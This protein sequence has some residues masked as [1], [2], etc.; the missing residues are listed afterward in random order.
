MKRLVSNTSPKF[1]KGSSSNPLGHAMRSFLNYRH[2][3]FEVP[4][5]LGSPCSLWWDAWIPSSTLLNCLSSQLNAR[6]LTPSS[7]H[8]LH[9]RG[10]SS[11][12]VMALQRD[13]MICLHPNLNSL[14]FQECESFLGK[15]EQSPLKIILLMIL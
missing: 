10:L 9:A 14:S 12:R 7:T 4:L 11:A 2:I 5:S 6:L 8:S 13:I 15:E 1:Q 3:V